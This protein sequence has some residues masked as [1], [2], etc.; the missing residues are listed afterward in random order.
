MATAR[1]LVVVEGEVA[2][3]HLIARCVRRAH[4]C[5]KDSLSGRSY[6]HRKQ[7][8][9]D[10]LELLAGAFAMDVG[11]YATMSNHLHLVVKSRPDVAADWS[12]E[13]VTRRWR[14]VFE[15][16]GVAPDVRRR[17]QQIE[18]ADSKLVASRRRRLASV[19]WFMRCLCEPI[20]R[21][22]NREDDCKGRFWEG[23]FAS[24][25]LLDDAAI[26]ACTAY[27][28]LNPVRVGVAKT[29]ETSRFVSI[30]DR[31]EQ[32]RDGKS[33]AES[34]DGWLA[35]MV[36]KSQ[37]VRPVRR[38]SQTPWLTIPLD[39]YLKLVDWS[40]RTIRADKRGSIPSELLPILERLRVRS[41]GWLS[42]IQHFGRMFKRSA[43]N[44]EIV[45]KRAELRG[46]QRIAGHGNIR[47]T[48]M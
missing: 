14:S 28:D 8:V 19:S 30:R 2:A 7:W 31:I 17:M 20:A 45:A 48:F 32:R 6:D 35:P 39:D 3:Y 41:T 25:A 13:E 33:E 27:V 23:R 16:H 40:G 4:L 15:Q 42:C 34:K 44:P 46:I 22:A 24:I 5:G 29:P 10:R 21:R 26:L 9:R 37:R 12:A 36:E 47:A 11:G 18:S 38:A 43:G 1:S